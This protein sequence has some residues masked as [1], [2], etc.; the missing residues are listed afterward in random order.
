MNIAIQNT[1]ALLLENNA[2]VVKDTDVY[3]TGAVISGVGQRPEGFTADRVIGGRGRLV[4]PGLVNAHTHS[5]MS[6]FRNVADDMAFDDWLFGHILP[7]E[8]RL[9]PEDM[10]WGTLLGCLEM[11]RTGTT[12][13]IDMNIDIAAIKRAVDEAG[14]RAVLSRGLVGKGNDEG[15]RRR[16]RENLDAYLGNENERVTF[17][18]GPHAPYSCD[19][20]Y[21]EIVMAE[22]ENYG[23]GLNIHL[24]GK[25]KRGCGRTGSIWVYTD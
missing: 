2:F 6:L 19:P 23:L 13:F 4:I 25:R 10:Y 9:Q 18:L 14:I 22:A 11:L 8:D 15:G 5:Y 1:K 17:M 7:M 12:C 3:I 20:E 24:V 21:L 16:L